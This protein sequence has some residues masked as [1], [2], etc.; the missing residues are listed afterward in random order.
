MYS[1][2]ACLP[3][4]ISLRR[5]REEFDESSPQVT[6][7]TKRQHCHRSVMTRTP[8]RRDGVVNY[9]GAFHAIPTWFSVKVG[10][11][12]FRGAPPQPLIFNDI[13]KPLNLYL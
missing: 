9:H 3:Q 5:R 2:F 1:G 7:D 6:R 10:G 12:S 13:S 4:D 11:A 8:T